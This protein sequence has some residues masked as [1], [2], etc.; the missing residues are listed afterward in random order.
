MGEQADADLAPFMIFLNDMYMAVKGDLKELELFDAQ[1]KKLSPSTMPSIQQTLGNWEYRLT[2]LMEEMQRINTLKD[3][4]TQSD[5]YENRDTSDWNVDVLS[6]SSFIQITEHGLDFQFNAAIREPYN[7]MRESIV[8]EVT[9]EG[10]DIERHCNCLAECAGDCDIDSDCAGD[11]VCWQRFGWND[12]VPPGCSGDPHFESHDYCFDPRNAE[13]EVWT[14][15]SQCVVYDRSSA[16]SEL[17]FDS[18]DDWNPIW[19]PF[20]PWGEDGTKVT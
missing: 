3:M 8:P 17:E 15:N 5:A 19:G 18:D 16:L 9:D 14:P 1:W 13:L 7:A 12:P 6:A 10:A 20:G 2:V 11:L 4:L